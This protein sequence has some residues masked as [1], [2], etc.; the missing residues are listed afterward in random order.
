MRIRKLSVRARGLPLR[1]NETFWDVPPILSAKSFCVFIKELCR[2]CSKTA[3]KRFV[4][5]ILQY[6]LLKMFNLRLLFIAGTT[7]CIIF[8]ASK[9]KFDTQIRVKG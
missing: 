1:A 6:V 2:K 4:L 3:L 8:A 9:S 5:S 7:F